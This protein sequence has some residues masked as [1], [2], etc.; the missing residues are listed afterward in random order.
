MHYLARQG[1]IPLCNETL[2]P[3]FP[4]CVATH[5]GSRD[6]HRNSFIMRSLQLIVKR[7]FDILV[8]GTVLIFSSPLTLVVSAAIKFDSRG[9]VFSRRVAYRYDDRAIKIFRFRCSSFWGTPTRFGPLLSLSGLERLP[10][11]LNV[12]RG[13][14]SI[15]GPHSYAAPPP[16]SFVRLPLRSST[17][18][19][20]LLN[21]DHAHAEKGGGAPPI[22]RQQ[23]DD[24]LF[25]VENWSLLLEAKILM[26]AIFS[27]ASYLG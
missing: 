17:F 27:K 21:W 24:D 16:Q 23:V 22:V 18:K 4:L 2:E 5:G 13:E 26:T 9:P 6:V 14:M 12:L 8:S 25:Y 10:M 20:G 1:A 15:I 7:A 19:P 11:L 3:R